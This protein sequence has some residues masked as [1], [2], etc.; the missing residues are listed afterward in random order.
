MTERVETTRTDLY[1]G[2]SS[3]TVDVLLTLVS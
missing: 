3:E 2:I 1:Y